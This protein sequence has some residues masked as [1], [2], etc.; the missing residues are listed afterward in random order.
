MSDKIIF[1]LTSSCLIW[2]I[3]FLIASDEPWTSDFIIKF[4]S[5]ADLSEKAESC[6]ANDKGF[7][8]SLLSSALLSLKI[9][10]SFSL[11]KTIKSSPAFAAPFIPKISTGVEGKAVSILVPLSFIIALILPHLNPLTKNLPF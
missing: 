8:P 2:L 4:N 1:G 5:S 3:A 6:V 7:L 9:L 11:S 10:A